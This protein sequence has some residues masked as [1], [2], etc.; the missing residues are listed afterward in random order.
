VSS[1]A[2]N[3]MKA[4]WERVVKFVLGLY[5]AAFSKQPRSSIMSNGTEQETASAADQ[6]TRNRIAFWVTLGGMVG[7]T[8]LGI[9]VIRLA[10]NDKRGEASQ[11]VFGSLLPLLGTWVGTVLAFYFAKANYESAANHAKDLLGITE[12]LRSTPVESVMLKMT[13]PGVT[14]RTLVPPEKPESLKIAELLKIL[15]DKGRNR[16]PVLNADGSLVFV[17]HLSV[18]TDYISTKALGAGAKPVADLTFSDLQTDDAQL[19]QQILAWACVKLGATLAEAKSAMEDIPGCSDVF[20]TTAGRKSD[21][22]VGW[23]TNVE[24]GLRSSA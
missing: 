16:L 2:A 12:R 19:Y 13:D 4:L 22:V 10:A 1:N 7:V 6:R 5:K 21:P 23:L 24:I 20:V 3:Q 17:I 15:R 8:I 9:V 14:K 11:L 18:L